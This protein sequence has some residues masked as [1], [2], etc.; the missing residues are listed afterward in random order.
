MAGKTLMPFLRAGLSKKMAG[1]TLHIFLLTGILN[2]NIMFIKKKK[3]VVGFSNI[4]DKVVYTN[5][6]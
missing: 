5:L 1:E 4:N 6:T 3:H 2:I